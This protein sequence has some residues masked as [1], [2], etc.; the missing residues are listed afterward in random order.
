[1]EDVSERAAEPDFEI[2]IVPDSALRVEPGT[3]LAVCSASGADLGAV[4]AS[5]TARVERQRNAPARKG[6]AVVPASVSSSR[7]AV[8][9]SRSGVAG[10]FDLIENVFLGRVPLRR[11]GP[12]PI[13]IDTKRMRDEAG[14]VLAEVGLDLPLETRGDQLGELA[15]LRLELARAL[16]ADAGLIVLDEP[17]ALLDQRA[18]LLDQRTAPVD[19]GASHLGGGVAHPD[20][21][22]APRGG[23]HS[24]PS[25]EARLLELLRRLRDRGLAIVVLTQRPRQALTYADAVAVLAGGLEVARLE[26]AGDAPGTAD[27]EA[28]RAAILRAMFADETASAGKVS[29]A[30]AAPTGPGA[31]TT[32]HTRGELLRVQGWSA[33]DV[34]RPE[35][36][37]VDDVSFE[38]GAGEIVGIAGLRRSGAEELLLSIFGRSAGADAV[39]E[40]SVLGTTVQT[41]TVEHAIA[42]GLF[43]AGTAHQRYRMQLLGGFTVPVS[44]SKVRGLASFGLLSDASEVPSDAD[45][46]TGA[47]LLGAVRSLSRDGDAGARVL[48]LLEAFPASERQVLLLLEPLE[49]AAPAE[50]D[51]ILAALRTAVAGG[52]GAVLVST[53]TALLLTECDRVVTLSEGRLTGA[54]PRGASL[55]EAGP[56][57]APH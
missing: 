27:P 19:D 20:E 3:I 10:G 54:L 25:E 41:D 22:G 29:T 48:G 23:D 6:T 33:H 11:L 26:V 21:T 38:V 39:G 32:S 56:L 34:L 50:R 14:R 24:E 37:V 9:S 52:K 18:A 42:A 12:I 47:K 15:R 5:A 7:M 4:L 16:T 45:R 40:V 2:P 30:P 28:L 53:D 17:T 36:I 13:G 46:G 8:I 44:Q 1:M 55:A 51:R 43:F 49:G 35:R 57:L 31:S